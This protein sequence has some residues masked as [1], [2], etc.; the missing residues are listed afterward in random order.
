MPDQTDTPKPLNYDRKNPKTS[1]VGGDGEFYTLIFK[2]GSKENLVEH[3]VCNVNTWGFRS[4]AVMNLS[5]W[6]TYPLQTVLERFNPEQMFKFLTENNGSWS[7]KEAYF[8]IS[9]SQKTNPVFRKIFTLSTVKEIDSFVNKAHGP[10]SMF[11]YRWSASKD[12]P[13]KENVAK[14]TTKKTPVKKVKVP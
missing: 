8:L 12:F 3:S 1:E 4:C 10:N 14:V 13:E 11:L 6:N 2:E 5:G 9:T 7:P